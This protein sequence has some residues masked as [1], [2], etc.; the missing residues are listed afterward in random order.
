[1]SLIKI[2]TRLGFLISVI[3]LCCFYIFVKQVFP[4][5]PPKV[6][7]SHVHVNLYLDRDFTPEED[8]LIIAATL[9]WT[10]RTHH[11]VEYDVVKLPTEDYI[12]PENSIIITKL[13][14]DAPRIMYMDQTGS[15]TLG[16]FEP[17][18]G[19]IPYIA[20]VSE[21]LEG[22]VDFNEVILHELGH[23]LGLKHITGEEGWNTLMYP[24]TELGADDIT[25]TDLEQFCK[26]YHCNA[27]DLKN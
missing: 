10:N 23:S 24:Y 1:M 21:R 17:N 8:E 27:E 5:R 7:P 11:I 2:I 26:L 25:Q 14:P 15:R 19:P 9:N 12:N 6:Y 4:D 22:D 18:D 3:L 20:L 16:Y 13:T